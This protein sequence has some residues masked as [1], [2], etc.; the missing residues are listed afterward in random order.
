MMQKATGH[1]SQANKTPMD[2]RL[3][4]NLLA[5]KSRKKKAD[6]EKIYLV[7]S[8]PRWMR[9]VTGRFR[10]YVAVVTMPTQQLADTELKRR[11]RRIAGDRIQ[12]YGL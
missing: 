3:R 4:L 12:V 8:F 7:A 9:V 2:W 11:C 1:Q 10:R 5:D 6:V